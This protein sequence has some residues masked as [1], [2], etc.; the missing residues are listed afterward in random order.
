MAHSVAR[1][2]RRTRSFTLIELLVVIGI[3]A[4]LIALLFPVFS[5]VRRRFLVLACPI[6]YVG[7]D[8]G[9]YLTSSNG[10]AEVRLTDPGWRVSSW[11]S[12]VTPI[13]WSP[14]GRR[15]S[16][17]A[18]SPKLQKFGTLIMEPLT[19]DMWVLP[20]FY[21]GGWIDKDT[22]IASG[23]WRHDIVDV[24]T[25]RRIGDFRL[26]DDRH[27]DTFAPVH[28][29]A[30]ASYVASIHGEAWI[31]PHIGLVGRDFMPK[32][33]IFS[34]PAPGT[35]FHLTPQIDPTGE[36][37]AWQDP[38]LH[39][40]AVRYVREHPTQ[41]LTTIPGNYQFCDWT[42]D[43]DLLVIAHEGGRGELQILAKDGRLVR[44]I[45]TTVPPQAHSV[46]A[47]RKLGHR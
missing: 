47:F 3:I 32:R 12:L 18:S 45:H 10:N 7:E 20:D 31:N 33:P 15:L 39:Q 6:A 13:A 16:V 21:F 36:W 14:C 28:P 29:N 34:W 24:N 2:I 11:D 35:H 27:Y 38:V 30:G 41:P 42:D 37:V 4:I 17:Q 5:R 26:P 44:R 46:A 23:A 22:C 9:L 8:S 43:G 19:A 1:R 40:V 25:R